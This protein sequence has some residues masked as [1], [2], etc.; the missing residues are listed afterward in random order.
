MSEKRR[1]RSVTV[2]LSSNIDEFDTDRDRLADRIERL[3]MSAWSLGVGHGLR[4]DALERDA[5]SP[6]PAL[7]KSLRRVE[8]ADVV[9][10][11]VGKTHGGVPSKEQ[12]GDGTSSYVKLEVE[13]ALEQRIPVLAFVHSSALT[14]DDED[15]RA[16]LNWLGERVTYAT[17]GTTEQLEIEVTTALAGRPWRKL[18]RGALRTLG[19]IGSLALLF[20]VAAIW[21]WVDAEGLR[22]RIRHDLAS[23]V[24]ERPTEALPVLW[25]RGTELAVE[26]GDAM[27]ARGDGEDVPRAYVDY[28]ALLVSVH[29]FAALPR[30]A[31]SLD[32]QILAKAC[33]GSRAA[34][35]APSSDDNECLRERGLSA[36]G[37][38]GSDYWKRRM[39]LGAQSRGEAVVIDGEITGAFGRALVL[40][41][42]IPNEHEI[43][44]RQVLELPALGEIQRGVEEACRAAK[45]AGIK[46]LASGMLGTGAAGL[47]R[48]AAAAAML[49]GISN[50]AVRGQ[51]PECVKLIEFVRE[52]EFPYPRQLGRGD[53]PFDRLSM[54]QSLLNAQQDRGPLSDA[55][56]DRRWLSLLALACFAMTLAILV[57][58][59]SVRR[60]MFR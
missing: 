9:L 30:Q 1:G 35:S 53:V 39:E 26:L 60:S 15:Q 47:D 5:A 34:G 57:V 3:P 56:A 51:C 29:S 44:D 17:W 2:F 58:A 52:G 45:Q 7:V 12:G 24:A 37:A 6:L 54:L 14:T 19:L 4:P 25:T 22:P 48:G 50:A 16:F 43:R 40:I 42:G 55:A 10:A 38:K 36:E 41:D 11:I 8:Q 33:E 31:R 59:G 20:F 28:D 32:C 21:L 13:R 27:L 23:S 46:T 49:R 18:S